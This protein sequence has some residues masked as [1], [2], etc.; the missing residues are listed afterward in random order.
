MSRHTETAVCHTSVTPPSVTAIALV[1]LAQLYLSH[2]SHPILRLLT[3]EGI[4]RSTRVYTHAIGQN[5][6]SGVTGVTLFPAGLDLPLFAIH[7]LTTLTQFFGCFSNV[8]QVLLEIARKRVQPCRQSETCSLQ[9]VERL[10]PGTTKPSTF[11]SLGRIAHLGIVVVHRACVCERRC[12]DQE[13]EEQCAFHSFAS[14]ICR[15]GPNA[16]DLGEG[17]Y[18]ERAHALA[19]RQSGKVAVLLRFSSEIAGSIADNAPTTSDPYL[20]QASSVIAKCVSVR[21]VAI[22]ASSL[23]SQSTE[24]NPLN[25]FS[26]LMVSALRCPISPIKCDETSREVIGTSTCRPPVG[27]IPSSGP[28]IISRSISSSDKMAFSRAFRFCSISRSCCSRES[29]ALLRCAQ[30]TPPKPIK[31]TITV[32]KSLR[33]SIIAMSGAFA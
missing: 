25:T 19:L 33:V 15:I 17:R 32:W 12:G 21:L 16:S 14:A 13:Y 28:L 5:A 31:P 10:L 29:F 11:A 4:K 1:S 18:A 24:S 6:F 8:F 30:I 22:N 26:I 2:P 9:V 3:R 23:L 20:F 7:S 27:A